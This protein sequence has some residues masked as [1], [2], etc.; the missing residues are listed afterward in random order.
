MLAVKLAVACGKWDVVGRVK[1]LEGLAQC[2]MLTSEIPRLIQ[3]L[4]PR[5]YVR[6]PLPDERGGK[7]SWW[8]FGVE[9]ESTE[10]YV[11]LGLDSRDRAR[12][13]SFHPAEYPLEYPCRAGQERR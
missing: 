2:N 5:H 4:T 8:V 3:L 13:L 9:Y 12:I 11:K 10:F 7:I 1:N 6:G